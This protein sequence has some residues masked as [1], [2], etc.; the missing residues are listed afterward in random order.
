[1][2]DKD[3]S[4][5]GISN[6]VYINES[7]CGEYKFLWGK[8]ERLYTE[9]LINSFWFFNGNLNVKVGE[10]SKSI[11]IGHIDDLKYLFSQNRSLLDN[12]NE[13]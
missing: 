4:G 8:C 10:G 9:K 2:K 5:I 1:M 11:R 3:L 12:N 13:W 6:D 7:L